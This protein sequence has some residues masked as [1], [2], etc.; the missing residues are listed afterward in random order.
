MYPLILLAAV[1][2]GVLLWIFT[3]HWQWLPTTV[4]VTFS[5]RMISLTTTSG[6]RRMGESADVFWSR[7]GV[8][9]PALGPHWIDGLAPCFLTVGLLG[10]FWTGQWWPGV[11]GVAVFLICPPL[12]TVLRRRRR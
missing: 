8:Q 2:A 3:G 4:G 9:R 11:V 1:I 12:F 5:L 6:L 10:S 7:S